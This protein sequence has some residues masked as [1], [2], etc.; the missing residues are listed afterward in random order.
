L[1]ANG[2]LVGWGNNSSGQLNIPAT[3]SNVIAIAAGASHSVA[4]RSDGKVFA[5]G[6]NSQGQI[7]VPSSLNEVVAIAAGNSHTLALRSDGILFAMGGTIDQRQTP[8]GPGVIPPGLGGVQAMAGGSHSVVVRTNGTAAAWGSATAT[9]TNIPANATNLMTVAAGDLYS[10]ALQSNGNVIAWGS[11]NL[12]AAPPGTTNVPAVVSNAV[13]ISAGSTFA[14]A[15]IGDGRPLITRQPVGGT[16]FVGRNFAISPIVT[17]TAPLAFQWQFNG[18]DIPDATNSALTLSGLTTNN[19]GAYQ[20]VVTNA[21]GVATSVPVP[22]TVLDNPTLAFLAPLPPLQTNFQ[23][24]KLILNASILGNGPLSYQWTFS[25]TNI[26]A[27]TNSDLVFDPVIASNTGNYGLIVSN[28]VNTL[29]SGTSTQRVLFAKTWGFQSNDPPAVITNAVNVA[30]TYSGQGS[31][32]GAFLALR[33]D[34]KVV[35]WGNSLYNL[36]NPPPSV[37]N[38]FITAISAGFDNALALRSDRT[39]A[40][41]GDGFTGSTNPPSSATNVIAIASGDRFHLVAR[42]DGSVVAWGLGSSGQ[43]NVPPTATNVSVIALA[44]GTAHS[45]ALRANGTVAAWGANSSGQIIVPPTATNV[46]AVS[47]G[48][49]HSLALRSDGTVIQWGATSVPQPPAGLSNV[50]AIAA[51]L[52]HSTALKNDGTL[53]TWGNTVLGT[54]AV[55]PDV[56]NVI[57]IGARGDRDIALFGTRAPAATIQPFDRTIIEG[58][59]TLVVAK[60]SGLQPV[61]YQWQYNGTNIP[62]ATNDVLSLT[63]LQ[64]GQSGAYQ[65]VASNSYGASVSRIANLQIAPLVPP[66]ITLQPMDRTTN[67]GATV[68]FT[69]TATGIN[70]LTYRWQKNGTN[71]VGINSNVLTLASLT[72]SNNGSY[73]VAVSNIGGVTVSSNAILKVLVPQK[74][75]SGALIA[76][77]SILFLS[78]DADGGLLTT[79][80]VAAFTA[81]GSSNL[82]DWVNL[83]NTLS[84]TNGLLLLS[85]PNQADFPAR[86]YRIIEQ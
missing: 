3:L 68:Q 5:W 11:Y 19:T 10:L 29:S 63:N 43:T 28:L 34:G 12:A 35:G 85:D 66:V 69:V 20:L 21:L 27:A 22:L 76:N 80:D 48:N 81:Q 15:I 64:T 24:G 25:G 13:A 49:L 46:I 17:G 33:A 57:Q 71:S 67:A 47:A 70:P 38:F 60:F 44:G 78:G 45:L 41:W 56:V 84:I 79:N 86:F 74:F 37:T 18:A 52:N 31:P 42:A 50:V 55:P 7:I 72:R 39:V 16:S 73:S 77:G 40:A 8:N 14:F 30:S 82:V 4:L 58:S 75:S 62:D 61:T 59:N 1:R 9:I 83:P 23:A 36:T 6:L 2:S 32:S 53:V 51:G 54:A 65:L 26:P